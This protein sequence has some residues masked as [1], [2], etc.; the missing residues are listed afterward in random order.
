MIDMNIK[1]NKYPSDTLYLW[2]GETIF[3]ITEGSGDNLFPEDE[4]NGYIDY[5]LTD[6]Y[7]F[8]NGDGG[9]WMETELISNIDYTIQGVINRIKEC[10]LWESNWKII[11]EEVGKIL[12][13]AFDN[14]YMYKNKARYNN[15]LADEQKE[16][17]E[18]YIKF[19]GGK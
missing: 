10:D 15:E 1:W 3:R 11:D 6:Y 7:N 5:W 18:K 19:N 9:Q 16:E 4:E 17:I 12:F 8:N 2:D 13:D 14:Y